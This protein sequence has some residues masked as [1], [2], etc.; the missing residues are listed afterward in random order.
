MGY[1]LVSSPTK[2][3][4]IPKDFLTHA[5]SLRQAFAHC[6]ISLIAASRRSRGRV[7]VPVRRI[8]LSDP[9]PVVGLVG[10][11]PPNYLI[12]RRPIFQRIAP[13]ARAQC[14]ALPHAVLAA[15]SRGYPPLKGRL[16]TCYATVRH[17]QRG[18]PLCPFDLH[19]LGTPLAFVLSQDQTLH[20][21]DV[22]PREVDTRAGPTPGTGK[23]WL[24]ATP[25]SLSTRS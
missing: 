20:E 17:S 8:I 21:N 12:G 9:L 14:Y 25:S 24:V 5:A 11:Y 13:L 4:Y 6:A 2:G 18:K 22:P 19:T 16:S 7:S 15:V 1:R 10:R 3:L 23:G